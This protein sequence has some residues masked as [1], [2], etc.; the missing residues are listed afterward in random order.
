MPDSELLMVFTQL[1]LYCSVTCQRCKIIAGVCCGFVEEGIYVIGFY[2]PV[3]PKAKPA[4]VFKLVLLTARRTSYLPLK[5][6][7]KLERNLE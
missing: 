2:Y 6:L 5:S 4:S 7:L 3:V 1:L